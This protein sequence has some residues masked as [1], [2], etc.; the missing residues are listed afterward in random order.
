MYFLNCTRSRDLPLSCYKVILCYNHIGPSNGAC[1]F[2]NHASQSTPLAF[3][4]L[5]G[6]QGLLLQKPLIRCDNGNILFSKALMQSPRALYRSTC[7]CDLA[8]LCQH[9]LRLHYLVDAFYSCDTTLSCCHL[10][11]VILWCILARQSPF[12]LIPF[13]TSSL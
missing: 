1:V 10:A 2:I 4:L 3:P 11:S 13:P 9:L 7:F 8:D 6:D 5:M 12:P